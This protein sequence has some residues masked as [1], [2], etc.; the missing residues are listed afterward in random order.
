MTTIIPSDDEH[1]SIETPTELIWLDRTADLLDNQF[2]LPG[3]S[4]RFGVDALIGL[5]PYVGD[6]MTIVI[7]GGMIIT[8]YRKGASGKLV[9]KM[10]SN[11]GLDAL[12][13]TIPILGD[14]FDFRY[15]SHRRNVNLMKEH[16]EEGKH[17]GSAW[18]MI[19]LILGFLIL[20]FVLVFYGVG[21]LLNW[22]VS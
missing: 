8:M 17:R 2:R 7:G 4:F 13:G 3:T 5:I 6:I 22:I 21:L 9:L 19:L 10:L 11:V 15:R 12:V 1:T 14:I 16:Y 18:G 20:L